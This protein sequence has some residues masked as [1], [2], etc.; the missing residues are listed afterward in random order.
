MRYFTVAV[1]AASM[2]AGCVSVPKQA[3]SEKAANGWR[4]KSVVLSDRPRAGFVAMTA[5]KGAFALIGAAAA[6][7]SGKTIVEENGIEDPAPVVSRDLLKLAQTRYGVLA[8]TLAP[9]KVDTTDVKQLAKAASGA[10][11]L[12]DVQSLGA[13]FNYFPTQWGHYWVGSGLVLRVIDVRTGQVLGGGSC[14]RDSR[15]EDNPPTKDDLLANK[16]QLLKQILA[17]QRD[18]CRDELAQTFLPV[19]S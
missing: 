2:V 11:L 5:G 4:G 18:S 16:A 14:H 3:V 10:D 8:A 6:I 15:K 9:V 7:E 19:Q 12:L 17:T 13:N 1:L